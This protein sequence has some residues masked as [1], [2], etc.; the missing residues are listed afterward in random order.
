MLSLALGEF[1]FS[2]RDVQFMTI[3]EWTLAARG[4]QDKE[5]RRS[6]ESWQ[7]TRKMMWA[8]LA[9][10]GSKIEEKDL[11][12]FDWEEERTP[13]REIETNE[14]AQAIVDYLMSIK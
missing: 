9:A 10:M 14:Q 12:S 6:R 7:Q 13:A 2:L 4:V 11:F 1:G 8:S 3:R 5:M